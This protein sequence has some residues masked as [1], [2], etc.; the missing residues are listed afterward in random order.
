MDKKVIA[1]IAVVAIVVVAAA[2]VIVMTSGP[3]DQKEGVTD[4][5][6]NKILLDKD[7]ERIVATTNI[8]VELVSDLGYMS[9]IVGA[10]TPSSSYDVQNHIVGMDIKFEYPGTFVQDLDSGKVKGIGS[11]FR[12]TAESVAEANPDVVI[13]GYDQL[14]SDDSKMKQLQ[15]LGIVVIV[16]N[17][18]YGFDTTLDNYTMLGKI[19]GKQ[20]VAKKITDEMQSAY[21][22]VKKVIKESNLAGKSFAMI[23][24]CPPYGD[25]SYGKHAVIS[26][27]TDCGM[28]NAMPSG[29]QASQ[30]ISLGEALA[31][32]NPDLVI[33]EDMS[34]HLDW[35]QVINEWKADPVMGS[36]DC[37]KNNSFYCL[38]YKPFQS[39]YHSKQS[40]NGYAL[41]GAIINPAT[42][43]VTVP[44]IITDADW[45]TYIQW[46]DKY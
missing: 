31:A 18:D 44:Q 28:V 19:L 13:I 14:S 8:G 32:A 36:I 1:I 43:G 21:D 10:T 3:G 11:Y 22:K 29:G 41:L 38:E 46:L 5:M 39:F 4:A 42:A 25:Y 17:T 16:L 30:S 34:M 26:M 37:I 15:A 35:T 12:W 2:A 27:L 23:S 33:F 40:I 9:K 45:L 7:P 6:G 24:H 20:S